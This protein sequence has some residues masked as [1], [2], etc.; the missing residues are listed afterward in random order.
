MI[1][2]GAHPL[3]LSMLVHGEAP[4]HLT[5][6]VGFVTGREVEDN[7]AALLRYPGGVLGVAEMSMVG[8]YMGYSL[9]VVG[10]EG[11]VAV[12]PADQRVMLRTGQAADWAEQ[13]LSPALADPFDQWVEWVVAG[14][15][16]PE[17]LPLVRNVTRAIEAAY[18][19][20]EA[21]TVVALSSL[22]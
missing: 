4:D 17:H 1:D 20:A 19:S 16:D 10:T 15:T 18:R 5:A 21:G 9:E 2:L 8:N 7:A 14:R 3:Y 11:S 13:E 6:Q 12:G 22:S